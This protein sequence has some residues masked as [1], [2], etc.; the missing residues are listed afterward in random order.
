MNNPTYQEFTTW[1]ERS[2]K[3]GV[4]ALMARSLKFLY[5][6]HSLHV[7]E[8]RDWRL[9]N[10]SIAMHDVG[11]VVEGLKVMKFIND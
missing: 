11:E 4:L 5:E 6:G 1:K 2:L 3:P 8:N 7:S 10:K 9:R